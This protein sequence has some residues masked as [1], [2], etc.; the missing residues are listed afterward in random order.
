MVN[1][2]GMNFSRCLWI[3]VGVAVGAAFIVR[4]ALS[5]TPMIDLRM[6]R[7]RGFTGSVAMNLVA[8]FAIVGLRSSRR[9]TFS[10]CSA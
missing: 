9:S 3:A 10:R 6:F 1:S 8:L 2:D 4:Q 5:S 7:G